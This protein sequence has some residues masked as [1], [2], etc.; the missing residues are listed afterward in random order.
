MSKIPTI[1]S[2]PV[3]L[4]DGQKLVRRYEKKNVSKYYFIVHLKD[5]IKYISHYYGKDLN[6]Y[7]GWA[8]NENRGELLE[9]YEFAVGSKMPDVQDYLDIFG[10]LPFGAIGWQ[11]VSEYEWVPVE[12]FCVDG[13]P[14]KTKTPSIGQL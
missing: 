6:N 2:F 9:Y 8:G 4:T 5:G 12:D 13:K 1:K 10:H 7:L 14:E 3:C 11:G